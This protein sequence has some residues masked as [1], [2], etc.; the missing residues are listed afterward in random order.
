MPKQQAKKP[1]GLP[2]RAGN[3]V[4]K[5]RYARATAR[6]EARRLA[7]ALKHNGPAEARKLKEYYVRK[8]LGSEGA[9]AVAEM[10]RT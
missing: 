2:K 7:H 4:R 9:R 8:S 3:P 10:A 6:R 5:L 1:K